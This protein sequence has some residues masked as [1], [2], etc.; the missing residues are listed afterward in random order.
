MAT[1]AV[2]AAVIQFVLQAGS[3]V[4]WSSLDFLRTLFLWA[5]GLDADCLMHHPRPHPPCPHTTC[6]GPH[7]PWHRCKWSRRQHLSKIDVSGDENCCVCCAVT[8][9]CVRLYQTHAHVLCEYT[10]TQCNATPQQKPQP[11]HTHMELAEATPTPH[12]HATPQRK[13]HPHHTSMKRNVQDA[14]ECMRA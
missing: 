13:P 11:R 5:F 14:P 4:L 10:H 1:A 2:A 9:A 6:L 8:V 7:K 3:N 12:S